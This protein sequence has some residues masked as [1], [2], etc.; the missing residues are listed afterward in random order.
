MATS[1]SVHVIIVI[2]STILRMH[3]YTR[4]FT[5]IF[6]YVQVFTLGQYTIIISWQRL[7]LVRCADQMLMTSLLSRHTDNYTRDTYTINTRL[8]S[9]CNHIETT[10]GRLKG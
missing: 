2:M 5:G 3:T 4:V 8:L 10:H 9:C 1:L 7:S 6:L